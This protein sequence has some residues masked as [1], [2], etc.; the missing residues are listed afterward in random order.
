MK[1]VLYTFYFC[2]L[3]AALWAQQPISRTTSYKGNQFEWEMVKD[4]VKTVSQYTGKDTTITVQNRGHLMRLNNQPVS[5]TFPEKTKNSIEKYLNKS[6]NR[7]KMPKLKFNNKD[8]R[9]HFSN[10]VLNEAGKIVYYEVFFFP[11]KDELQLYPN[12]YTPEVKAYLGKMES[13]IDQAPLFPSVPAMP[14]YF[15]EPIVLED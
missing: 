4:R 5:R 9:V 13:I 15:T 7:A 12:E 2:C 10:C 14:L 11:E 6:V 1:T 3:S 8:L